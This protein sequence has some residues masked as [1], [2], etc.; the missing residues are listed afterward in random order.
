MKREGIAWSLFVSGTQWWIYMSSP[1]DIRLSKN[2]G[3]RKGFS[4]A[5][6]THIFIS[7][8]VKTFGIHLAHHKCRPSPFKFLKTVLTGTLVFAGIFARVSRRSLSSTARTFAIFPSLRPVL[9]L[10]ELGMSSTL[11]SFARNRF[12]QYLILRTASA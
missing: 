9:G 4:F 12:I 3:S 5:V 11:G 6:E 8:G 10:P 1:V 7:T 2:L